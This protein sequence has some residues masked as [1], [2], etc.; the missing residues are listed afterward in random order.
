MKKS[1]CLPKH[2]FK[3]KSGHSWILTTNLGE[4]RLNCTTWLKLAKSILFERLLTFQNANY[5]GQRKKKRVRRYTQI[6][7]T[8]IASSNNLKSIWILIQTNSK[9]HLWYLRQ[10]K[11]EQIFTRFE[12]IITIKFF[13]LPML[14]VKKNLSS[15]KAWA[16]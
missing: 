1:C 5:K 7:D 12:D 8:K 10:D 11:F 6:K 14:Y 4:N 16:T 2:T 15:K 13:K 3:S 9:I